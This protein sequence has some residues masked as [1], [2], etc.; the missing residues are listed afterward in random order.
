MRCYLQIPGP[1]VRK[2]PV[3]QGIKMKK[4][5]FMIFAILSLHVYAETLDE[6]SLSLLISENRYDQIQYNPTMQYEYA[7]RSHNPLK[8]AVKLRNYDAIKYFLENDYPAYILDGNQDEGESLLDKLIIS[9][10]V[11]MVKFL[12][13]NGYKQDSGAGM[14]ANYKNEVFLSLTCKA[15]EILDLFI[16]H[17]YEIPFNVD[18]RQGNGADFEI[19]SH[20]NILITAIQYSNLD[21]FI[22]LFESNRQI[23]DVCYSIRTNFEHNGNEAAIDKQVKYYT[24]LDY[25]LSLGKAGIAEFIKNHGG[26]SYIEILKNQNES[27]S[28]PSL[29]AICI[30]DNLRIRS[31]SDLDSS[32]IGKLMDKD[33]V[34]VIDSGEPVSLTKGGN[35]YRWYK[36][37]TENNVTGWVWGEYLQL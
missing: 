2:Y 1:G 35:K 8:T 7:L 22:R 23:N 31:G 34:Y 16:E 24:A 3:E 18:R 27:G 26:S 33:S 25:A 21:T 19:D 13:E 6:K 17:G 10:D 15:P 12:L 37:L 20:S 9:N 28:N 36:I 14:I 32:I 4:L 30:T 5:L 29:K 11:E